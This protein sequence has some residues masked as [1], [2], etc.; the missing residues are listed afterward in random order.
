M[1]E[2]VTRRSYGQRFVVIYTGSTLYDV[3]K[4][5]DPFNSTL[6]QRQK[7]DESK[8]EYASKVVARQAIHER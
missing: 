6:N 5:L 4:K 8:P 1:T 7:P 2:T 3:I